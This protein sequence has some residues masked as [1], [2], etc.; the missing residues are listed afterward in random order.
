MLPN[1]RPVTYEFLNVAAAFSS[2]VLLF[3]AGL[4]GS[5]MFLLKKNYNSVY[6][7]GHNSGGDAHF[8]CA[9]LSK[10]KPSP[11]IIVAGVWNNI[12]E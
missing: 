2:T 1:N 5:Y 4:R 12:C 9:T 3:V 10:V 8:V 11:P 6:V 7:V